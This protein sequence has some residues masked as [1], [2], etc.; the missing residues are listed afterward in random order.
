MI[1]VFNLDSI[2]LL[3]AMMEENDASDATGENITGGNITGEN[4]TGDRGGERDVQ[5]QL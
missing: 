5:A 3:H 4:I 2:I 1:F